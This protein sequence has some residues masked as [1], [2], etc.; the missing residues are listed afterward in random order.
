MSINPLSLIWSH[1]E[2]QKH[3]VSDQSNRYIEVVIIKRWLGLHRWEG[4]TNESWLK[5]YDLLYKTK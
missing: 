1:M 4:L 3:G 2:I 5:E